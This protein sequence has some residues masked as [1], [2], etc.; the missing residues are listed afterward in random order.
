M[1]APRKGKIHMLSWQKS[2]QYRTQ[3]IS[4]SKIHSKMPLQ[5]AKYLQSTDTDIKAN[6]FYYIS[7]VQILQIFPKGEKS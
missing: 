5:K 7:K 1:T 6:S 3:D 4:Q 2:K